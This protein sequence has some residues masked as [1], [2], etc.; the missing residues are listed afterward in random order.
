MLPFFRKKKPP[1]AI[2][3]VFF[4]LDGT[5]LDVEI[6]GFIS[7]YIEGLAG[8]FSD[9][10]QR[11]TFSSALREAMLALLAG[12]AG[13]NSNE[14]LFFAVLRQ[15]LGIDA[16][17]F[18]DRLEN[19]CADGLVDLR[20]FIRPLPLARRILDQCRARN[21]KVVLAT[22]PVFPRSII[23]ARLVWGGL[24]EFPFD[25]VTSI[26]NTR[27]CKPDP[28]YFSD[29]L[30]RF[31]LSP[32]ETLM[33]GNDTEHDLAACTVGMTTFLVDT[34]LVDR[35]SGFEPDHRGG[36]PE[37]LRFLEGSGAVD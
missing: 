15:R 3:A 32:K 17:L 16:E 13:F 24:A 30:N 35:G 12:E 14:K 37:L 34:W 28:R 8:H 19:Y 36:H 29:L 9:V 6:N 25:L 5:L 26:E 7:A 4:D 22:N 18:F 21:L 20:P 11:Y 33:V 1:T 31:D 23:D 27:Y 10:V 2:R